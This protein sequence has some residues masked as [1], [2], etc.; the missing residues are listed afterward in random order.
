[1]AGV[2]AR[3]R[4]H[5][6]PGHAR[7]LENRMVQATTPGVRAHDHVVLAS[8]D[9][10]AFTSLRRQSTSRRDRYLGYHASG[11][12]EVGGEHPRGWQR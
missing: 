3:V 5:C 8:A 4:C 10:E 11:D 6:G 7:K 2:S 9:S 12:A 1:L